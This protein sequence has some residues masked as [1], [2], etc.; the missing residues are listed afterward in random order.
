M[1]VFAADLVPVWF[2]VSVTKEF[3]L[4][5]FVGGFFFSFFLVLFIRGCCDVEILVA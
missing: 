3:G 4:F 2:Y 1:W 5:G